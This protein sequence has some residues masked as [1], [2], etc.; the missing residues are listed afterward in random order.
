MYKHLIHPVV[1]TLGVLALSVGLALGQSGKKETLR[2]SEIKATDA[3]K[4]KATKDE[5]T[6]ELNQ[7]LQ[8][9]YASINESF[10][11]TAKFDVKSGEN[12][13]A[14]IQ[15]QALNGAVPLTGAN[16]VI[17]ATVDG[18]DDARVKGVSGETG[19]TA[20]TRS[21]HLTGTAE[22]LKTTGDI[23]AS[24]PFDV[25]TNAAWL[26][27]ANPNVTRD[28]T[29]GEDLLVS[30]ARTA[31]NQIARYVT[32]EIHPPEVVD[33]T[34]KSVTVDWGKAMPIAIGE[35]W[36]VCTRSD[37]TNRNGIVISIMK[38]V[39]EVT[40]QRVDTDNSTGV[41]S[42]EHSGIAERCVL[43]KPQ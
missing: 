18:F 41:I 24:A 5:K 14:A 32:S 16:Y 38:R 6:P 12:L 9:L 3:V 20:A 31:A 21:I 17:V 1:A 19:Q 7:V 39:G 13:K 43:R 11:R 27:L 4:A 40:I 10:R 26:K 15:E 25:R 34:D 22:I 42:G 30:T 8:S 29:L 35:K 28:E 33:V 37:K 36:E 23:L 2:V